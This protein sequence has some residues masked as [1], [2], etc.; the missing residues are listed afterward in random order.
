MNMKPKILVI[1]DEMSIRFLL[2]N[3]L[4]QDYQVILKSNGIE[5]LEWLE[6]DIPELIICSIQMPEMEGYK[7]PGKVRQRG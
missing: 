1:D 3:F 6:T 4:S 7:L 2:D 5:A